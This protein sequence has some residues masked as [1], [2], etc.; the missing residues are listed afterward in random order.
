MLSPENQWDTLSSPL[1]TEAIPRCSMLVE[2]P[3]RRAYPEVDVYVRLQAFS[4]RTQPLEKALTVE[5]AY[6]QQR[7]YKRLLITMTTAKRYTK[8]FPPKQRNTS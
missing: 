5:S 2:T 6:Y 8:T 7:S 3:R 1:Y 4:L